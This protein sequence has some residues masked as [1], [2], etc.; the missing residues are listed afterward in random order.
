LRLRDVWKAEVKV[1]AKAKRMMSMPLR[2]D[3]YST[4]ALTLA[5]MEGTDGL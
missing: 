3:L 1:K 5:W 2:S 4:L